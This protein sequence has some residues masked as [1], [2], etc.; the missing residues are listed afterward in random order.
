MF[1]IYLLYS[2][3]L[4]ENESFYIRG[5]VCC[6]NNK[7]VQAI[8][9]NEDYKYNSRIM[10]RDTNAVLNMLKI[11]KNLIETNERPKKYMNN[12]HI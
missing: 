11:V 5:R 7:C 9:N 12:N 2:I 8:H 3:F 6:N 4:R 10:N 1:I